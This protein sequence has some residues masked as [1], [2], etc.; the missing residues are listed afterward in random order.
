VHVEDVHRAGGIMGSWANS[1]GSGSAQAHLHGARG[2]LGQALAEWDVIRT[3]APEVHEF[4]RAAPGGI[5]TT[6]PFSQSA[7]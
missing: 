2:D 5:R 4:F 7:L 1:T 3:D 6:E